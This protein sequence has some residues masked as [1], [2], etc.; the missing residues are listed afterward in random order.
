MA[1]ISRN[2][3]LPRVRYPRHMTELDQIWSEMLGQMQARATESGDHQLAEYLRLRATNDAIRSRGVAWLFDTIITLA[4]EQ[5]RYRSNLMIEREEP[6]SFRRGNSN[7]VGS[8][9]IVRQGVRCLTVA[10][11]W[12]RTP[13]DGIMEK[14][15]LAYARFVHFGMQRS[16]EDLRLDFGDALPNWQTE[17][18]ERVDVDHVRRHI[19]ILLS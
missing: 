8:A 10:A 6:Y 15:A 2:C 13:S 9:V 4:A 19:D 17:D 5:Q 18:R 12:V 14:G 3:L 1:M 7:L 11:G 16:G